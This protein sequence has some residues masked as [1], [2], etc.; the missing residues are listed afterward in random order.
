MNAVGKGA[1]LGREILTTHSI[2]LGERVV[3]LYPSQLTYNRF[4]E[5]GREV[6]IYHYRS[7]DSIEGF[8]MGWLDIRQLSD[9]IREGPLSVKEEHRDAVQSM[10]SN[11]LQFKIRK[12]GE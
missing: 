12:E 3:T 2:A 7:Q 5:I 11:V 6:A 10:P 8:M 9:V 1:Q 4:M